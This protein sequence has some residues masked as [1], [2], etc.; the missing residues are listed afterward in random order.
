[1]SFF[2][3]LTLYFLV[4]NRAKMFLE[5]TEGGKIIEDLQGRMQLLSQQVN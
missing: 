5:N 1:M 2:I 4:L 3:Q